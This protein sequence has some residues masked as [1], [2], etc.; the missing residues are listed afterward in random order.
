MKK[1]I[2][3]MILD[4]WGINENPDQVNAIRMADPVNFNRYWNS[5]PHTQLRADGEFVGLPEGQFGNSEVGHLNIG[6]GR[7]VYQLLPK[8]TKAIKERTILDNK[9]LSDIMEKTKE[10]GKA[11]HLTGLM[12][13]GGV[14]SHISH[15]LGVVEMAKEKGLNEVYIHAIMDGRDTPPKSGVNYLKDLE[16]GLEKIGIGKT[17]SVVGRYYAMDR[18]TNWERTEEA[19]DLMTLGSGIKAKSSDEAITG[20]YSRDE[21]D[22][23]VKATIIVNEDETPVALVKDGDGIIFCNFRPDRARQLTRAFMEE[24][25]TGFTRKAHPKVSFVCMAQYDEKF[26]LP[27]AYPPE[28]IVNTFGEILSKHGMKQIR[29][30]ETEKYAHVTFFFNGGVEDTYPGE[31]RLLTPSPSVAT[32]DLK[33]EMSAYEVTDKLLEELQKGDTDVVILNFANTDMVGHTGI[34]EAEI[35]AVKAVD[36]CLNKI[37]SKV[38]EMEGMVLVTADHG[39]G[40]LMVDPVTKAP[41][42]AHTA[43]PVPFILISDK[44]KNIKLRNDGKL[45]DLTP[46]I[47]DILKIEKPAEMTGESLIVK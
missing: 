40:D 37:A 38:L 23:F 19:Y 10:N 18:D 39:N 8:I 33:P 2:V 20:A 29:T 28:T 27:V 17:A 47:L 42:T 45:A 4:G 32:Y 12:S 13:D 11:L 36:E 14:H 1:P 7:V 31:I 44:L 6:A 22:E 24:P 26:G 21:T 35:R 5:Y 34:I 16:D 25:F 30:A 9:V 3:L 43:N 15:I 41:Y 46:T